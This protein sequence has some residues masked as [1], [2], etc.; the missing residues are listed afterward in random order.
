M[1]VQVNAM[2]PRS[3]SVLALFVGILH[4]INGVAGYD[5]T[6]AG[7]LSSLSICGMMD[8]KVGDY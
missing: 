3:N 5:S 7:I 2:R 1:F 8:A 4:E 6:L